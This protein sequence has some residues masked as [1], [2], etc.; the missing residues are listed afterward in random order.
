MQLVQGHSTEK[1]ISVA[2]IF[3]RNAKPINGS[4]I[5]LQGRILQNFMSCILHTGAD[6]SHLLSAENFAD[7]PPKNVGEI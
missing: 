3:K 2:K 4:S 5:C 6:F 7:F 1:S